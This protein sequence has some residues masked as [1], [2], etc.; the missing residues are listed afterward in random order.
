[1]LKEGINLFSKFSSFVKC[2]Y[3]E[4]F[5]KFCFPPNL[6][7]CSDPSD[8]FT[9]MPI[10]NKTLISLKN[11]N[12]INPTEIQ[13]AVLPHAFAGHDILGAAKTGSGKTLAFVIPMIER[14]Y[15]E[16]WDVADG[17]AAIIITPTRELALQIFDVIR[18]VG[19]K[20]NFSAGVVTG[21]NKD[22]EGEQERVIGMN[23]L[24]CTPGRLLQHMEQT[25]GFDANNVMMLILDEAD[26]LL[27]MG[28]AKQLDSIVS[29]LP[30]S[31]ARQTMLFSATQTKSV[32][33]LAR[34]SLHNPEYL[35]V[36]D[37]DEHLTPKQLIQNYIVCNLQDKL[38]VLYSFIKTHLKSKIIV[39]FSTCSQVR[40]VYDLFCGM[41]P[42]IP[43]T[44]LHGKIKQEKRTLIYMEYLR[45]DNACLLATDVAA[46][47][48]DFPNVD[49]V[50]QLDAPED[51]AMYVHRV[52]RTARYNANGRALML[53]TPNEEQVVIPDL[54]KVGIPI[55][56][57]SVN[58][59]S[60]V[61]VTSAAGAI[62][63]ARPECRL[64]AKK[65]FASYL[66]SLQ[67]LPNHNMRVNDFST[68]P[69]D[70]YAISLGL[71]FTPTLPAPT[72]TASS[73]DALVRNP[74]EKAK[75]VNRSLD[76]LKK[77]IKAAKEAKKRAREN[78]E[79]IAEE[80]DDNVLD[81]NQKKKRTKRERNDT[82]LSK[83]IA[84]KR[85]SDEE[86]E[87]EL[88]VPKVG[89]SSSVPSAGKVE[90][91]EEVNLINTKALESVSGSNTYQHIAPTSTKTKKEKPMRITSDGLSK[92]ILRAGTH[93]KKITFEEEDEKHER[94]AAERA[95]EALGEEERMMQYQL[96][97]RRQLAMTMDEDVDRDRE[98]IHS[99]HRERRI[100][101]KESRKETSG[102]GYGA[103]T[104]LT[105]SDDESASD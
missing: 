6:P 45:K 12:L 62:T 33:D 4:D 5:F 15:R 60:A 46:R 19:K 78:N 39:F 72:N 85:A 103:A 55:Q 82:K 7:S 95:A 13:S 38:N 90:L 56:K 74:E 67:M 84:N 96:K 23:I 29:Y 97:K 66:R 10:S 92:A 64:L 41:Q 81:N 71:P 16:K 77:Q 104:L 93:N 27:D 8:I 47:G 101:A 50:I 40:F 69:V 73:A 17:L 86:E 51:H 35:A 98:R 87:D 21:G 31:G 25:L 34:L 57:L 22:L 94:E 36:H 58:P 11:A 63:A 79:V 30:V 3:I 61:N 91:G 20:H 100:Q 42:G 48:L 102:G 70:E 28:F 26:R 44:S 9:N 52:G 99:K 59:K 54:T 24:V 105:H 89:G 76:K 2:F 83:P 1:M 18:T 75:N 88:F 43:I 53:L 32:K 14:L 65:A 68:L 80:D 37:K 49:W